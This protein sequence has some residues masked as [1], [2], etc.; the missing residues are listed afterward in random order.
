MVVTGGLGD[1]LLATPFIRFFY[2]S[3]CYNKIICAIPEQAKEI[4]D[5]N[6]YI[7]VLIPCHG[8]DLFL[9]AAPESDSDIFSPYIEVGIPDKIDTHFNIPVSHILSPNQCP[10]SIVRQVAEYHKIPLQD[11]ALDIYTTCQD[12]QWAEDFTAGLNEKPGIFL[13][14]ES[15][16][17]EKNLPEILSRE[18]VQRLADR[19]TIIQTVPTSY[20]SD[21]SINLLPSL[22]IRQGAALFKRLYAIL[23][24]DSFPGHLAWAVGTPAVV[25][26]GPSNPN[27]FGHSGNRNIRSN[28]CPPCADTPRKNNCKKAVCLEELHVDDILNELYSLQ[29][30]SK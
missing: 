12:E 17:S 23:T 4:F 20:G 24:V 7:D 29:S 2:K 14:L 27:V 22:T 21:A 28:N 9:W 18:I 6:P 10:G 15:R 5:Q 25:I 19:F 8:Q 11:E 30:H 1:C 13:N 3:G 16:L 26:F